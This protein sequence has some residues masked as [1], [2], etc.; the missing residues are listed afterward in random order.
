MTEIAK[1]VRIN[2]CLTCE[3]SSAVNAYQNENGKWTGD[4][5]HCDGP[6]FLSDIL[7]STPQGKK[8]ENVFFA[9]HPNQI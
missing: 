3:R 6:A 9:K 2:S 1:K 8:K 4:C 5:P 7:P